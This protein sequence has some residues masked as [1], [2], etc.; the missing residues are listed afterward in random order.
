[1]KNVKKR[2]EEHENLLKL[3]KICGFFSGTVR[4]ENKSVNTEVNSKLNLTNSRFSS[5]ITEKS[6]VFARE[7]L[8][9]SS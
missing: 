8:P 9:C 3:P 7:M 6:E 1:M 2:I 5:T 4:G